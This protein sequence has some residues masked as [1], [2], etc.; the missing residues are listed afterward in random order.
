[1]SLLDRIDTGKV[2]AHVAIIMD[3][4]GRWAKQKN[5]PR[6]FGHRSGVESVR[7]VV[8]AARHA[9][10]RHLTLYAFSTENWNRPDREINALMEILVTSL[11]KETAEL[12]R[13]GVKI[14][15]LGN[16]ERL[17]SVCRRE[18]DEAMRL[19]EANTT[20]NLNLALSYSGRWDIL[21]AA[22]KLAEQAA[23]G[24]L[25]PAAIDESVFSQSLSTAGTPDPELMIRTSG[26]YRIS[27]YL[28]W[29]TAYSELYF[30]PTLWPDFREEE[31]Y[32]AL[33]DFQTRERRFGKTS[34]Q[35]QVK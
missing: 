33:L 35:I 31:F 10:V 24:K 26:E 15:V 21:S 14:G 30:T 16:V 5:R 3:G 17:P 4:N 13:E 1:M 8:R 12:S 25:D 6:V 2:P 7:A 18:L 19:T 29:Q 27:N 9:K 22:R 23:A 20:L 32:A 11:R 34:E 28:L